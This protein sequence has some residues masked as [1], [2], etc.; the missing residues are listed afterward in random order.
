MQSSASSSSSRSSLAGA[1]ATSVTLAITTAAALA[2]LI[3]AGCGGAAPTGSS[4]ANAA[5]ANPAEAAIQR[6]RALRLAADWDGARA[7]IEAAL[8]SASPADRAL[9]LIERAGGE[10]ERNAYRR[11]DGFAAETATLALV[12]PL[13]ATA[14][15]AARAGYFEARGWLLFRK[16]F[17][18]E[19]TFED[20]RKWFED[21]R[22]LR[23]RV[24]TPSELAWN[25]F[26]I[27][28]T[29]QMVD[30]PDEARTAFRR[31]LEL[32]LRAHDLVREGY[33]TR[34]IG[35]VEGLLAKNPSVGI[36]YYERSLAAREQGGHRWGVVFAAVLVGDAL[37]EAGE[38][39]RARPYYER[40]VRD[41]EA[42]RIPSGLADAHLGL[43]ELDATSDRPAACRHLASALAARDAHGGPG[44]RDAIAKRR[45]ELGCGAP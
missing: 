32:A 29:Y 31:G 3:P 20:A 18:G 33:L 37:R 24:G 25:D 45:T 34:H 35:Y 38:P 6:S 26:Q 23:E 7:A 11:D 41:G 27:G 14:G 44:N 2:A 30:R 43:A 15:D 8:P 4:T 19:A 42:L 22:A 1:A 17:R 28:L 13:V 40:A 12:E 10:H 39:A 36:P 5:A 21:A 16:S 9:L